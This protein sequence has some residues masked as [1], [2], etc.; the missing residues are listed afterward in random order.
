MHYEVN[1]STDVKVIPT[2]HEG[3]GVFWTSGFFDEVSRLPIK[4][5]MWEL[6]PGA[7]EGTLDQHGRTAC[8]PVHV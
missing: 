2:H 5:R 8:M 7:S 1:D 6:D 4:F 3:E